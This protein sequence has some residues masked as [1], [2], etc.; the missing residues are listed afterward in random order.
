MRKVRN[1]RGA[2]E[3]QMGYK[4]FEDNEIQKCRIRIRFIFIPSD[5]TTYKGLL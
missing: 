2:N 1:H 4:E 3:L 5:V